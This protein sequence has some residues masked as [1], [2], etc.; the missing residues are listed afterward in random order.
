MKRWNVQ[1]IQNQLICRAG[2]EWSINKVLVVLLL[3]IVGST[4]NVLLIIAEGSVQKSVKI[5]ANLMPSKQ[6]FNSVQGVV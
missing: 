4:I 5:V 3:C 1:Q 6:I 2:D